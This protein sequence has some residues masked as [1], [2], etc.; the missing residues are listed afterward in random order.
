MLTSSPFRTYYSFLILIYG[1]HFRSR[2][3]NSSDRGE[4]HLHA[5]FEFTGDRLIDTGM[6]K[7]STCLPLMHKCIEICNLPISNPSLPVF[8]TLKILSTKIVKNLHPTSERAENLVENLEWNKEHELSFV[9]FTKIHSSRINNPPLWNLSKSLSKFLRKIGNE[10]VILS[11][12]LK[13]KKRNSIEYR[14]RSLSLSNRWSIGNSR[15][16]E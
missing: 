9:Y 13:R 1:L 5:I 10:S 16:R 11:A 6:E 3:N 8:S 2:W 15:F 7:V 14:Y 4:L 12:R